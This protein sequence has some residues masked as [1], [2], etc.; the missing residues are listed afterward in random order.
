MAQKTNRS[1][2]LFR[3]II[4]C[5]ISFT[6]SSCSSD[7][8]EI[9]HLTVEYCATPLGID[10]VQ[11]RFSWQMKAPEG[12]RGYYQTAYR[13][14][15]TDPSGEKAWDTDKINDSTSLAI[16]YAGMPLQPSTRYDWTVTVWDQNA[17][18]HTAGSW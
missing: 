8:A 2:T 11:P 17:Q 7:K 6:I 15:V 12:E 9:H 18:E 16:P 13:V 10:V 5:A 14:V 4:I 3:G 1:V